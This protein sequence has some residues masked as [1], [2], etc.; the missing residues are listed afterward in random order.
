MSSTSTTKRKTEGH[1]VLTPTKSTSTKKGKME[2]AAAENVIAVLKL[3]I[4]EQGTSIGKSIDDLKSSINFLSADIQDIKSTLQTTV[5][6]VSK[7]E[8]KIQALENKVLELAREKKRWNLRLRGMPE[9]GTEDVRLKVVEVCQNII[10]NYKEKLLEV[11]DSV[12]RLGKKH[13]TKPHPRDIIIQF[14]MKHFRNMIW[15]MAKNS[16]YLKQRNL[17]FKEDLS[18]EDREKRSRLWPIIQQARKDKKIAYF[19][20]GR[21]FVDGKEIE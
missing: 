11:I 7:A 3:A 18:V 17:L 8:E 20:G 21:A 14:S 16:G 9:E 10:P 6:R 12:H 2:Q 5:S 4:E 15:K 19:V 13:P 1:L